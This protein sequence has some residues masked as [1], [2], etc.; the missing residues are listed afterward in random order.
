VELNDQARTHYQLGVVDLSS[1]S[2]AWH[3]FDGASLGS[4]AA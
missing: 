2:V 4:L 1:A 3:K